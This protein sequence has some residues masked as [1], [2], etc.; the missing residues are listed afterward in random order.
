MTMKLFTA[1]GFLCVLFWSIFLILTFF[2]KRVSINEG[3]KV[4][5]VTG[6]SSGIGRELVKQMVL[7]GWTVIGIARREKL[8]ETLE[9]EI[10]KDRFIPYVGDVSDLAKIHTISDQIKARGLKPT[11]FFL[12]AG[13]GTQDLPYQLKTQ[14]HKTT[15]DVNYFGV[16]AWVE[17]WL[18]TVKSYGGGTFVATSSIVSLYAPPGIAAYGASKAALN[19]CF[20][21]LGL[22]YLNDNISFALILPGPVATEMLKA[23]RKMP[24]TQQPAETASYTID[25][26]F[27]GERFIEPARFYKAAFTFLRFL[28]DS[29][30]LKVLN[31]ARPNGQVF[32]NDKCAACLTKV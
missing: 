31:F 29:A 7:K 26:I 24:F 5:L 25:Q 4:C 27:K 20:K 12:N 1:I 10:G 23:G 6:A 14:T 22:Q 19:S 30:A 13:T 18:P 9:Q 2:Q 8:L 16:V 17:E 3:S 15:F 32:C 28:P 11:L 21:T